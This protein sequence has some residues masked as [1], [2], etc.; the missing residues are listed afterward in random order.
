MPIEQKFRHSLQ[1]M[2]RQWDPATQEVAGD[3]SDFE[4][5]EKLVLK[6]STPLYIQNQL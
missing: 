1:A 2:K 5:Q 3:F 4:K 6:A